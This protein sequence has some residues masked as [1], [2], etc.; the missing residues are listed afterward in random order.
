MH[1]ELCN[2]FLHRGYLSW[3][4]KTLDYDAR[5]IKLASD[6]NTN[7]PNHVVKLISEALNENQKSI[8]GSKI[9]H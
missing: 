6:I 9:L 3:K 1:F 4:L 5:F 8:N 7:M 2:L